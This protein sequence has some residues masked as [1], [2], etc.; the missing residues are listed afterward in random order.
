M[1]DTTDDTSN[2][3]QVCNFIQFYHQMRHDG[4]EMTPAQARSTIPASTDIP[5]DQ[6]SPEIFDNLNW[7]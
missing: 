2:P 6:I 5:G 3:N 7:Y 1:E 4:I